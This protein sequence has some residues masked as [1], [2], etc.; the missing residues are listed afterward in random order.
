MEHRVFGRTHLHVSPLALGTARFGWRTGTAESLALLDLF[1]GRGGNLV[2]C[3]TVWSRTPA[4]AA[5]FAATSEHQVGQWLAAN[6]SCRQE[7]VLAS[8]VFI[9]PGLAAETEFAASLRA[10]CE[11]SLQRLRTDYLDLLQIEWSDT[12]GPVER[13]LEAL[14]PLVSQGRLRHL[15]AVGFPAWRVAAANAAAF[16]ANLPPLETVQAPCS[17]LDPRPYEREYAGLCADGQL[18]FLAQAPLAA[19][20]LAQKLAFGGTAP[21][22]G[23]RPPGP[24]QL[25]IRERLTTVAQRRGETP[26]QTELAWV[27]SQPR[28]AAAVIDVTSASQLAELLPAVAT[29]LSPEEQRLLRHPWTPL[30]PVSGSATQPAAALPALALG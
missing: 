3:C 19:S 1:R 17:L 8:R 29:R 4:L 7:L 22:A 16:R 10:N 23:V 30:A 5:F 18:A 24:H 27:L 6:P 28:V 9:D 25:S 15:G 21:R 14:W 26:A 2:E 20:L 13:L 11:A 12:F